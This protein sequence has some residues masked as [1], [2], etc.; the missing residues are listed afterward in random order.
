VPAPDFIV[1][2]NLKPYASVKRKMA[3][4]HLTDVSQMSDLVRGRIFF[5]QQY[6][7]PEMLK[8]LNHLLGKSIKKVDKKHGKEYGLE[9]HGILHLDLL[10]DGVK[11]ELQLIPMEF[12]P[13]KEFLHHIYQKLRSDDKLSDKQKG[14]LRKIHNK[15]YRIL[16]DRAKSNRKYS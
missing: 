2:T 14:F 8:L 4:D 5:S 16:D 10:I 13:Y 12:K 11:F 7:F 15:M 9:Y 3:Q 6:T 1:E